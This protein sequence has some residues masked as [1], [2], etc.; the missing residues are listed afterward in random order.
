MDGWMS[1]SALVKFAEKELYRLAHDLSLR[2]LALLEAKLFQPL[3]HLR[4]EQERNL[5]LAALHRRHWHLRKC[6]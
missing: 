1:W 4:F 6:T 3:A 5:N 2:E